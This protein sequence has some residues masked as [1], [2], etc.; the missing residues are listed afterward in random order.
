MF[1]KNNHNIIAI[2]FIYKQEYT[3][4]HSYHGDDE[5]SFFPP[6]LQTYYKLISFNKLR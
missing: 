2:M 1:C 5:V 3:V 4:K 6:S